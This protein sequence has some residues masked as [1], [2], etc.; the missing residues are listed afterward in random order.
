MRVPNLT[1]GRIVYLVFH[2]SVGNYLIAIKYTSLLL[3]IVLFF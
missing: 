1:R 2:H 3:F